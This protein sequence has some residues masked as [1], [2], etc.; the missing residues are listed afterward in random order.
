VDSDVSDRIILGVNTVSPPPGAKHGIWVGVPPVRLV[1]YEDVPF[2]E[3]TWCD[4]IIMFISEVGIVFIPGFFWTLAILSWLF[5]FVGLTTPLGLNLF[6][7]MNFPVRVLVHSLVAGCILV[8]MRTIW[9][10]IAGFCARFIF[11]GCVSKPKEQ[12]LSYWSAVCY[13][14]RIYNKIW[15][16]FIIPML[17]DGFNGS[18]IMNFLVSLL[19]LATIESDVLISHY[20]VFKDHNYIKIRKGATINEA[21]ILRTHTFEDWRLKFGVVEIGAG[22]TIHSSSTVMFGSTTLQGCTIMPNSLVLKGETI[23]ADSYFAGIPAI[24]CRFKPTV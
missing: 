24:P 10:V 7:I 19:S 23:P 5:L 2:P 9:G 22:S 17:I 12:N 16:F 20:G 4:E 21:C 18:M 8:A 11:A 6:D 3:G 15:A 14:W 1:D 13:R